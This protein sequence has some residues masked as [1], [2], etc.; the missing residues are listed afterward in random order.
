MIDPDPSHSLMPM[1]RSAHPLPPDRNR[2]PSLPPPVIFGFNPEK[3]PGWRP[4]QDEAIERAIAAPNRII[5]ECMPT[6]S[7]KSL[8][9][10]AVHRLKGARTVFL[11]R[12]KGLQSQMLRDFADIGMVDIRGQSSYQ[13]AYSPTVSVD[14][15]P[16]HA[17]M[18]CHYRD[19]GCTYYD[20][21]K[22]ARDPGTSSIVTNYSF[23]FT[24]AKRGQG[25]GKVDLLVCDEAH[26]ILEE[27]SNFLSI[28]I[29]RF[30]VERL[31]LTFPSHY[32]SNIDSWKAWCREIGVPKAEAALED[33]SEMHKGGMAGPGQV[34]EKRRLEYLIEKM[35]GLTEAQ[36]P[37]VC[38]VSVRGGEVKASPIWPG[39]YVEKYLFQRVPKILMMSATIRPKHL[40]LLGLSDDHFT[41]NEVASTFPV[42]NRQVWCP[43][44]PR[45]NHKI[46]TGELALWLDQIDNILAKR[47]DR[48]IIIHTGSYERRNYIMT[49]SRFRG[50][51]MGHDRDN[52]DDQISKFKSMPP[53]TIFVSQ[54]ITEGFDFSYDECRCQ[55]IAKIPYAD[56]R[57]QLVKAR[58]AEDKEYPDFMAMQTL[59]QEA[60]RNVRAEDDWGETI[61]V[62]GNTKWFMRRNAK[63]A[64][65]HFNQAVRQV[66]V[67][68]DPPALA[69][70]LNGY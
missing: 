24:Q 59:V 12:R 54:S 48:R 13:C 46:G 14:L 60:G 51:M 65:N 61:I 63:F 2:A 19:H 50:Y 29:Q 62:D 16:C 23:W 41:Y 58:Q 35:K 33:M 70:A 38:D 42:E 56:S 7:G 22:V 9:G 31:G 69:P 67:M 68:P 64:P 32:Q 37:W 52:L 10:A 43:D 44:A 18:F 17:G 26:G 27:L 39:P 1:P 8:S 21:L 6:G 66:G 11:T 34:R 5:V 49:N 3:F 25:L 30:E 40:H 4:G 57:D 28:E 20:G 15:G 45:L 47:L 53:P 55:I 36:G